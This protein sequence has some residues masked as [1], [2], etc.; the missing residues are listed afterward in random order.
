[1]NR[2]SIRQ[3]VCRLLVACAGSGALMAVGCPFT[4]ECVAH[5][6]DGVLAFHDC[7]AALVEALDN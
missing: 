3:L 7:S 1:M 4:G 2:L 6:H 5:L